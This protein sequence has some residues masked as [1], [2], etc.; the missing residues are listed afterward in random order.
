VFDA[1][2][3]VARRSLSALHHRAAGASYRSVANARNRSRVWHAVHHRFAL[4]HCHRVG[5]IVLSMFLRVVPF[6]YSS[7]ATVAG[8]RNFPPPRAA[9]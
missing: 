2:A 8:N 3:Q 1:P 5:A 4:L 9:H 6:N 7:D